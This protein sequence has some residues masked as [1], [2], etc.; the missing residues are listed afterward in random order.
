MKPRTFKL[1]TKRRAIRINTATVIT[2]PLMLAGSIPRAVHLFDRENL[3]AGTARSATTI[4]L[5]H[6]ASGISK[7]EFE[8]VL[9]PSS[10]SIWA[11]DIT[12]KELPVKISV[13]LPRDSLSK[14]ISIFKT[15][16][17]SRNPFS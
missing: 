10:L 14:A 15:L 13:K 11:T 4:F 9:I 5:S 8:G 16:H 2:A 3:T 6:Y 17:A 7:D 12:T 1:R